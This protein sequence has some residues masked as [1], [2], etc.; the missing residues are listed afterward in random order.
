M[1]G[2]LDTANFNGL[3]AEGVS[4]RTAC[5]RQRHAVLGTLRAGEAWLNC[6]EVQFDVFGKY[7][8][9][10]VL[11]VPDALSLRVGLD[12]F[13]LRGGTTRECQV[14]EGDLVDRKERARGPVFR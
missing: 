4:E 7:R 11:V 3:T 8:F 13:E 2:E 1:I 5:A 9:G 14:V 12:E 6:G 10:R